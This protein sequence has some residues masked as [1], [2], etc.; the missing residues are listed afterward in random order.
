MLPVPVLGLLRVLVILG[1]LGVLRVGLVV[2]DLH[3]LVGW[4]RSWSWWNAVDLGV[5]LVQFIVLDRVRAVLI[6]QLKR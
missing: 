3:R 2:L 4:F 5:V 1:L 6:Y